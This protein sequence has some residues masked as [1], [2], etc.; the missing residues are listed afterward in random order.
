MSDERW[1]GSALGLCTRCSTVD[2]QARHGHKTAARSFDGYKA[3]IGIDPDS[4]II[5]ATTVTPGNAGDASAAEDLI[6][7]LT[8]SE[9]NRD[10]RAEGT[11]DTLRQ[12][13][14]SRAA[15]TRPGGAGD[16]KR[17][18]MDDH[19]EPLEAGHDFVVKPVPPGVLR[20]PSLGPHLNAVPEPAT[21]HEFPEI[22]SIWQVLPA[23]I[24]T[25]IRIMVQAPQPK[26][27]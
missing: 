3:H 26:H 19:G 11:H 12:T 22:T 4:E 14:S 27:A 25:Q 13:G 23:S 18:T 15:I 2:P 24:P 17:G 7:D 9:H 21:P 5:T 8:A 1:G 16:I 20:L 6:T 10:A